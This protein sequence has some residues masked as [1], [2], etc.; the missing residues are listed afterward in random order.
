VIELSAK[1]LEFLRE[2]VPK[3]T[4][5]AVLWNADDRGM[6]LRYREVEQAA[7]MLHVTVQ[8]FGV[9][10]PDDLDA[11]F[12]AMTLSVTTASPRRRVWSIFWPADQRSAPAAVGRIQD[13]PL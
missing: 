2:A 10:K 1:R 12:S 7:Q 8:P 5:I 9:R 11:A 4:R 6:A 13:A 3:A